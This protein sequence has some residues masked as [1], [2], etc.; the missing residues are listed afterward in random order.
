MVRLGCRHFSR[1][2][3]PCPLQ[4]TQGEKYLLILKGTREL[5]VHSPRWFK[6]RGVS[7]L[8]WQTASLSRLAQEKCQFWILQSP[9]SRNTGQVL[10]HETGGSGL[11][12]TYR[13]RSFPR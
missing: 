5:Q 9:N 11:A 6:F 4:A 3:K 13:G 12:R 1:T 8:S 2:P 7:R 10:V